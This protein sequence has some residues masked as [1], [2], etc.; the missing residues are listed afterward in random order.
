MQKH[1]KWQKTEGISTQKTLKF[2]RSGAFYM[3]FGGYFLLEWLGRRTR[4]VKYIY[5]FNKSL[6]D[7]FRDENNGYAPAWAIKLNMMGAMLRTSLSPYWGK[8]IEQRGAQVVCVS[9]S[10]AFNPIG[11]T[12]YRASEE[13]RGAYFGWEVKPIFLF[14]GHL[15]TLFAVSNLLANSNNNLY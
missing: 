5:C 12:P 13:Q 15:N 1:S 14:V 3:A 11:R 4:F 2:H 10:C 9:P 6:T 8:C 7:D